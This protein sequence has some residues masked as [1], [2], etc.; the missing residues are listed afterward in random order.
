VTAFAL[1][2]GSQ[3]WR[4]EA[5]L[6]GSQ[7]LGLDGQAVLVDRT[8]LLSLDADTGAVRW[9]RSGDTVYDAAGGVDHLMLLGLDR[10]T[11]L[12]GGGRPVQSWATPVGATENSAGSI[13]VGASQLAVIGPHGVF[14]G[15]I[16]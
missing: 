1:R 12:D 14:L 16:R 15:A 5:R 2:D 3:A 9:A 4:A 7:L 11:L 13:V 10:V 8:Q 6:S